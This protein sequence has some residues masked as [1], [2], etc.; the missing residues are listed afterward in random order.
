[1]V[2]IFNMRKYRVYPLSPYD[3]YQALLTKIGINWPGKGNNKKAPACDRGF[4]R[5]LVFLPMGE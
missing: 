4:E 5:V 1:M 2:K 3:I